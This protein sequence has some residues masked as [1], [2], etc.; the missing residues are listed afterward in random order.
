MKTKNQTWIIWLSLLL[1]IGGVLLEPAII[2]G[3]IVGIARPAELQR[4][5]VEPEAKKS[6]KIVT[7]W[8]HTYKAEFHQEGVDVVLTVPGDWECEVNENAAWENKQLKC[9]T[10]RQKDEPQWSYDL[11]YTDSFSFKNVGE[12]TQTHPSINGASKAL[13]LTNDGSET[14]YLLL[15]PLDKE[16]DSGRRAFVVEMVS[17]KTQTLEYYSDIEPVF[18]SILSR[19]TWTSSR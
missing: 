14:I 15:D 12:G 5:T 10:L 9:M 18:K 16:S 1:A 7:D 6:G 17:D 8:D 19:S 2:R 11:Y 4:Q 13:Q 3:C